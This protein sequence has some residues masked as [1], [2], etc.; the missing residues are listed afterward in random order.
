MTKEEKKVVID[1]LNM[2]GG[3]GPKT[4]GNHSIESLIL[5]GEWI[6][7]WH[8]EE[9]CKQM[10]AW[11]MSIGLDLEVRTHDIK[12]SDESILNYLQNT[13][14]LQAATPVLEKSYYERM[15]ISIT[16]KKY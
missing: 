10:A 5:M 14:G 11:L 1:H 3:F 13:M 8:G 9:Y 15:N 7:D 2:I 16:E 4:K 12:I 6:Y